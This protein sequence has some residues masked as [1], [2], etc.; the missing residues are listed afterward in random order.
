MYDHWSEYETDTSFSINMVGSASFKGIGISASFSSEFEHVKSHQI[1]D[2][3]LTTKVQAR[4]VRYTA[5]VLPDAPLDPSFHSRLLKIASHIRPEVV[6]TIRKR[7]TRS[8][9]RNKTS[10][11]NNVKI[12]QVKSSLLQ[13]NTMNKFTISLA[14][15]VSILSLISVH[16]SEKFSFTKTEIEK[17]M[18]QVTVSDSWTYGGPALNPKNF[19]LGK[20]ASEI[21]ND[22]V[23][24]DRNGFPLD[25][26]ITTT[27]LP[28]LSKSLVQELTQSIGTVIMTYYKHNTYP[29]CT[30]IDAPNFSYI[31]N[32][33]DRTCHA[34]L[35]NLSFGGL[36]QTCEFEGQ[37]INN[38]DLCT[39][40]RKQKIPKH[41]ITAV[42]V[43]TNK[44]FYTQAKPQNLSTLIHVIVVEFSSHAAMII[45]TTAQQNIPAIDVRLLKMQRF[46]RIVDICLVVCTLIK[47]TIS[48]HNL[49]LVRNTI[50]H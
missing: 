35:T 11:E 1:E 37:L 20:W 8:R 23:P 17:Y 46:L 31:A 34:L 21:D 22:L 42:K 33:E 28:E 10:I 43:D 47:P 18:K 49:N 32:V 25:H 7:V 27:A 3:S 12:D 13:E 36:F 45:Y 50:Y 30:N 29:G 19:T 2:K 44:H 16:N 4:Y 24:V 5:K 14:A 9:F 40:L 39:K 48:L 41:K 26:F 38:E 6:S 15:S